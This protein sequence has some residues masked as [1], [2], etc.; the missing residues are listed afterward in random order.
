MQRHNEANL[1]EIIQPNLIIET[2]PYNIYYAW[3]TRF[4]MYTY[5]ESAKMDVPA[6]LTLHITATDRHIYWLVFRCI[7]GR[8]TQWSPGLYR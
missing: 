5:V 6:A 4:H 3:I 8:I 7:V 2:Q 1:Y